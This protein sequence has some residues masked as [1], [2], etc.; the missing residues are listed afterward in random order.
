MQTKEQVLENYFDYKELNDR[1]REK[2]FYAMSEYASLQSTAKEE[3]IKELAGEVERLNGLINNPIVKEFMDG[4]NNE[5]AHQYERWGDETEVPPHHFAMVL[6]YLLGKL[7]K[8]IFDKDAEKFIHHIIT[9]AA[10]S[11]CVHKYF[12]TNGSQ[13]SN[14]FATKAL[15]K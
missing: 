8:A 2:I 6:G 5:I 7:N 10:V 4:V 15:S 13:V 11:G 12:F 9:C 14:W 3:R 1:T